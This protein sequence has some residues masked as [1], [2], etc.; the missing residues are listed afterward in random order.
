M[1]V[2]RITINNIYETEFL[3]E[4]SLE[5]MSEVMPR[6]N[7]SRRMR[8]VRQTIMTINQLLEI[9]R[10]RPVTLYYAGKKQL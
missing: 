10:S 2:I 7:I 9:V 3:S 8:F 1:H 5:I 4:I 6:A